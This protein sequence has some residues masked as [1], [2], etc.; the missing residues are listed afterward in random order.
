ME[1]N[2]TGQKSK[3]YYKTKAY[4][5]KLISDINKLMRQHNRVSASDFVRLAFRI[6]NNDDLE[7]MK[8]AIELEIMDPT[9]DNK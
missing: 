6:M 4:R 5:M 2:V 3:A 7:A 1:V 8:V 9:G